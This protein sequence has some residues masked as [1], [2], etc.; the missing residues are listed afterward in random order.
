MVAGYKRGVGSWGLLLAS[1]SAMIGSGWLLSPF[2]VAKLAGPASI[3]S[4]ILGA[5][6]IFFVAISY[7]ELG[8]LIPVSGASTRIPQVTHGT[9]TSLFFGWITWFN[10]MTAPAIIVQA[11]IEYVGRY[12]PSLIDESHPMLHSL[13]LS[14]IIVAATLMLVFSVINMYSIRLVARVNNVLSIPKMLIPIA[15]A[16]CLIVYAFHPHNFT[17]ASSG[18]FMP[19]GWHGVFA[20]MAS[21]GILFAFN[22]FK[23]SIELAGEAQNPTRSIVIAVVGSIVISLIIYLLLQVAFI[24]AVSPKFIT[25]GWRFLKFPGDSGPLVGLLALTGITW[26]VVLLY[27]DVIVATGAAALVYTTSAARTLYGLSGNRQLPA[28]LQE[29]NGKGVPYK[30]VIVN[31][32]LGMTFFM[33]FHGW[34]AMAKFMSSIVALSYITGPVCC[35]CLRYQL[36]E[37]ERKVKVPVVWLWSL[38]AL[39]SC[40]LIVYWT[41][42]E[43]VSRLGIAVVVSLAAYWIYRIF[44]SRPHGIKMHWPAAFWMLPYLLGLTLISYLGC[45]DGGCSLILPGWDVVVITLLSLLTLFLAVNCR[46]SD[47]HV[48][49][50]MRLLNQEAQTGEPMSIP[51]EENQGH[52]RLGPWGKTPKKTT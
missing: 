34:L 14:G 32:V 8:T 7:C 43:V 1:V 23:Q 16:V 15:T 36:P 48:E 42:W 11:M 19:G 38:I 52:D 17:L 3:I 18:G 28:F 47:A 30:A 31:F 5:L 39:T 20:G 9:F 25:A 50:T 10:L 49:E 2:Y 35:L 6:M 22:G 26:M 27:I 46:A 29:L 37:L 41:G 51:S 21:G 24:G 12:F 44:S 33:P 45:Y 13:S 40:S 4:W